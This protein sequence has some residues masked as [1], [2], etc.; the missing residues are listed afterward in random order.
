V[1]LAAIPRAT[2]WAG[3][4]AV[5]AELA[6]ALE[7]VAPAGVSVFAQ[8]VEQLA[9]PALVLGPGVPYVTPSPSAFCTVEFRFVWLACIGRLVVDALGE[10]EALAELVADSCG[11]VRGAT[12]DGITVGMQGRQLAGLD[13]WTANCELHVGR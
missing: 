13:L 9:P 12:Y 11:A 6:A 7:A 1:T 3:A 2:P 5:R 4:G 8:P 10:L